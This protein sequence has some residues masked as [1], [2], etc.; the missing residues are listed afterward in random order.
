MMSQRIEIELQRADADDWARWRNV[1]LTALGEAPYA[2]STKLA[3]WQAAGDT[4]RRWRARLDAVPFNIL[5]VYSGR[6][7]G[8]VSATAVDTARTTELIS[9]WVA[10][11][12]RGRHVGDALITAVIDWARA[13]RAHN[14]TLAVADGNE[15]AIALYKRHGFRIAGSLPA[16]PN[17]DPGEHH[18]VRDLSS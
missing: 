12:A 6:V 1:R 16:S 9:L 7:A 3:D 18:M 14:L 5:A 13:Q 10:P 17:G 2:F 15:R 4:E 11:F 8:M